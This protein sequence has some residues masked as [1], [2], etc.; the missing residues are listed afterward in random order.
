MGK[1]PETRYLSSEGRDRQR[2]NA[3]GDNDGGHIFDVDVSR[4]INQNVS[5]IMSPPRGVDTG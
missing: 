3:V 2:I 1:G 4:L 5:E